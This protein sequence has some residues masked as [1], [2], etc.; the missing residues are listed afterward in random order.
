MFKRMQT[1]LVIAIIAMMGSLVALA[2]SVYDRTTNGIPVS[3]TAVFTNKFDNGNLLLKRIWLESAAATNQT[4]A[5]TRITS[6][7]TYTQTVGSVAIGAATSGSTASFTA[8]YLKYGDMLKFTS[9]GGI[10][11][12]G[13]VA[14]IEYEVQQH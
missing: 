4:V 6:D 1:A 2:G 14:I 7:N 5:I 11:S 3:G 8:S 9:T 12:T 10:A 13:G